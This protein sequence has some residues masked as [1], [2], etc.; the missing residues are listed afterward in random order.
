MSTRK[1]IITQ[2]LQEKHIERIQSVIPD[3]ELITGKDPLIWEK[4]LPY[5]EII[6]GWKSSMEKSLDTADQLKWIQSWSAG[7]NKMP[8]KQLSAREISVTSATGVHAYPISETIFAL[9]LGLTR[10]IHAYVKNQQS[11]TWHHA[12]LK[13]EIHNKTIGI[14][15]FGA[16]GKETA[17][18]AKAFNMKVLGMRH[19]RTSDELADE[20]F[21]PDQ[22]HDMLPQCDFVVVTLPLTKETASL[23]GKSEFMAMKKSAY[24]INIG[25]GDIVV[26]QEL[27][28]ALQKG[29]IAGAGLDVFEQEP[30]PQDSALW[31]MENVMI[32][33]HTAGSTEFYDERVIDNILLPNLKNYL[34]GKKPSVNLVDYEKGY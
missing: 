29:E 22:L 14:L 16:I 19:S 24:F 5:A 31:E 30:L 33:P 7:V 9:L 17:R 2:N 21:L 3:W 10:K 27:I 23:F 18:I 6:G 13:L 20:M 1:M 15:G 32:T 25:R 8:L 28:H 11:K 4:E 34:N 26:E 12:G